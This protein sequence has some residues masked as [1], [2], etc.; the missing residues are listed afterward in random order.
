VEKLRVGIGAAVRDDRARPA[1][2]YSAGVW[3]HFR[4]AILWRLFGGGSECVPR[5]WCERPPRALGHGPVVMTRPS[6]L[7]ARWGRCCWRNI[8]DGDPVSPPGA[9]GALGAMG[10]T[11]PVG[12]GGPGGGE[13]GSRAPPPLRPAGRLA[14]WDGVSHVV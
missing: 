7:R 12:G 2:G 14:W 1:E 6:R 8:L 3:S 9:L 4:E 5:V 11:G 13:S 10:S